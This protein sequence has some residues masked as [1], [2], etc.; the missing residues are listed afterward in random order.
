MDLTQL[1]EDSTSNGCDL[2][3]TQKNQDF[4]KLFSDDEPTK[5]EMES[6]LGIPTLHSAIIQSPHVNKNKTILNNYDVVD[7]ALETFA[8]YSL[9]RTKTEVT[10]KISS[11]DFLSNFRSKKDT[12]PKKD[13][14]INQILNAIDTPPESTLVSGKD[15]LAKFTSQKTPSESVDPPPGA[16]T[17]ELNN[18]TTLSEASMNITD[19]ENQREL[20]LNQL[21]MSAATSPSSITKPNLETPQE[22]STKNSRENSTDTNNKNVQLT[23]TKINFRDKVADASDLVTPDQTVCITPDIETGAK[24]V[25]P[26]TDTPLFLEEDQCCSTS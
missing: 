25:A 11:A 3:K 26:T 23:P 6:T 13:N 15:F 10:T 24:P 5:T 14:T 4:F 16:I 18:I 8:S 2:N 17:L 22:N 9:D 21:N 12:S 20:I 7:K 19:D 1:S